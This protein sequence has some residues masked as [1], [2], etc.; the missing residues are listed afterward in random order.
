MRDPQHTK[1]NAFMPFRNAVKQFR[2]VS[3]QERQQ[4]GQHGLRD[5][6]MEYLDI[7]SF[8]SKTVLPHDRINI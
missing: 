7:V 6:L 5:H 1:C 4:E 3:P 2:K 8:H